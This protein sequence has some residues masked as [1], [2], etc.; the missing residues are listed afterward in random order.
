MQENALWKAIWGLPLPN[1][2]ILFFWRACQ[3]LLPTKE[4]LL[5]R[6]VINDPF[7]PICERDL[8]IVLHVIWEC[9]T[10]RDVWG[11]SD[12]KFQKYGAKAM[13]FMQF[14]ETMLSTCNEKEF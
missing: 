7:C 12:R 3:N 2:E 4:N 14:A 9:P 6:K 8:E 5:K 1:A 10:A 13:E 11:C